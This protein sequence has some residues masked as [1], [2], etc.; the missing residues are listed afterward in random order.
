MFEENWTFTSFK[1]YRRSESVCSFISNKLCISLDILLNYFTNY[2]TIQEF[3]LI[4]KKIIFCLMMLM[5]KNY[6]CGMDD[7]RK[8]FIFNHYTTASQ[9]LT[10]CLLFKL[11]YSFNHLLCSHFMALCTFF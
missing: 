7:H 2:S 5:M 9:T 4:F 11:V 10:L 8:A 1:I 6:I 3:I